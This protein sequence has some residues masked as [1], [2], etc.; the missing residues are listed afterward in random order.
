M[1]VGMNI[2]YMHEICICMCFFYIMHICLDMGVTVSIQYM[3]VHV[4]DCE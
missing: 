2:Q 1:Y 4:C 3:N